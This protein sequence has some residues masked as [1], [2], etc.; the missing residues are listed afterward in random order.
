MPLHQRRPTASC[1]SYAAAGRQVKIIH[2]RVPSYSRLHAASSQQAHPR[3]TE[4]RS[5]LPRGTGKQRLQSLPRHRGCRRP[6]NIIWPD[7]LSRQTAA[8]ESTYMGAVSIAMAE[9]RP[10]N[11]RQSELRTSLVKRAETEKLRRKYGFMPKLGQNGARTRGLTRITSSGA[12]ETRRPPELKRS[13]ENRT[14]L[15]RYHFCRRRS[16][17]SPASNSAAAPP[18]PPPPL[19]PQW[20]AKDT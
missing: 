7:D 20:A 2:R 9:L 6:A 16:H 5:A 18:L 13:A 15:R 19:C 4:W 8:V 10:A 12:R 1:L 14:P 11:M 17:S 3:C